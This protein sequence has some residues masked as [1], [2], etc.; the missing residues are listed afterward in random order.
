MNTE[1]ISFGTNNGA[2]NL[3][4]DINNILIYS[5]F[6]IIRNYNGQFDLPYL[7]ELSKLLWITLYDKKGVL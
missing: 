5:M 7:M 1:N 2:K 3:K 4:G 6:N